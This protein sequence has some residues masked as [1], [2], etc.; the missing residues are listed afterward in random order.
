MRFQQVEM[1]RSDHVRTMAWVPIG[2]RPKKGT[3]YH[4]KR[5]HIWLILDVY[6]QIVDFKNLNLPERDRRKEFPSL[7]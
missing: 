4:D 6:R 5:G 2:L 7:R 1:E 3:Y